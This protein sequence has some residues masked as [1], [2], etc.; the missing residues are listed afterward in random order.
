MNQS[1][2]LDYG[3]SLSH[4]LTSVNSSTMSDSE[5]AVIILAMLG[6]VAVAYVVSSIFRQKIFGKA[7]VESWK[8]WVPI[9][10]K[11]TMLQLG[12]Q[13]G[14]WIFFSLVPLGNVISS[15]FII[16]A[17]Y[18]IQRKLGKPDW[19]LVIAVLIQPVWLGM[20]AF[21]SSTWD[22]SRGE[23]RLDTRD[24]VQTKPMSG[25]PPAPVSSISQARESNVQPMPPR[26]K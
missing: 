16:I 1:Y 20:L 14:W 2:D 13:N 17:E 15:A 26:V 7:G 11:Y 23:K 21:D 22:D 24:R 9:Y 4:E 12:G 18:F 8:A 19:Y 10:N 25:Q 6:F 5:I 3:N